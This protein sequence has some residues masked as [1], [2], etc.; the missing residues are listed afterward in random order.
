MF[1]GMK[2]FTKYLLFFMFWQWHVNFVQVNSSIPVVGFSQEVNL[3]S[4]FGC[5]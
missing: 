5:V 2:G 3:V 4:S 1:L